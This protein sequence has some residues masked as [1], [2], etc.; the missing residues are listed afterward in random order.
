[1][2]HLKL[3]WYLTTFRCS[4]VH[5]LHVF[6]FCCGLYNRF[7]GFYLSWY[8]WIQEETVYFVCLN[9]FLCQSKLVGYQDNRKDI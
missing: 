1:M 2:K 4:V 9:D 6:L 7:N 3:F 5:V 8:V